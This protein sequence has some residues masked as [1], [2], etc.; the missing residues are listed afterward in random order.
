MLTRRPAAETDLDLL[1]DWNHQLIRDEG[2]RN[3]MTV[4]QLRERMKGWLAG[5]YQAV[6][7]LA[8]AEPVAYSLY[9]EE[10]AEIYL[11]QLFVRRDQRR[12]GFGQAAM[13]I[14]LT[15]VWPKKRLTVEVL[16]GHPDA[17]K[18]YRRLGYQDY[19]LRLEI[20]PV[21]Q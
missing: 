16:C 12:K 10:A 3:P 8:H 6:L 1:A 5:E 15:Q 19:S 2:H 4:A 9:K 7:F 11:R 18:F 14:L 21:P 20:L 13:R 17:V